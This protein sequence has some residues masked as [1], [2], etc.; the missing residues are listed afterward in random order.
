M[1]C[2]NSDNLI[3]TSLTHTHTNMH[4]FYWNMNKT[5]AYGK[6]REAI[7]SH[8]LKRVAIKIIK[9]RLLKKIKG[10]EENLR[11]EVNI[12]RKLKHPNVIQLIEVIQKEEKQKIYIVLEFAG[13]GSLQQ[14]I[15]S[16]PNKRLPLCDVWRFFRQFIEGLEYIVCVSFFVICV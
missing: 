5:G 16:H 7:D 1:S 15:N 4:R 14:V 12:M 11:N 2:F 8:T 3:K 10:G 9:K 13:A 6:V